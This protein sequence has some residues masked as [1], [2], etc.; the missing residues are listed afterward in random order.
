LEELARLS[1]Q[2]ARRLA[3]LMIGSTLL[4]GGAA[5][6]LLPGPGLLVIAIGLA[7]L[8]TEFVWARRWLKRLRDN[9][10]EVSNEARKFFRFSRRS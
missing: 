9:L 3:I 4:V 7:I 10:G 8:A 5:L 2:K 1:Y 6:L